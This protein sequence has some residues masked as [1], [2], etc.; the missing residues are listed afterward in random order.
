MAQSD[1]TACPDCGKPYLHA[2]EHEKSGVFYVHG[3][4]HTEGMDDLVKQGCHLES[5]TA[6]TETKQL[7]R[8]LRE[9]EF[10]LDIIPERT[11]TGYTTGD[12]WNGWA[13]PLFPK[14]EA[15]R[16]VELFDGLEHPYDGKK[17]RAAYDEAADAFVFYDPADDSWTSFR[18]VEK[19]GRSLY[20]IGTY[21]WTWQEAGD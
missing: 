15:D 3:F 7:N 1:E 12:T 11:F 21:I 10:A 2:V 19:D 18:G 9:T 14:E 6:T 8:S 16:I 17:H 4:D 5:G 13:C 20:P